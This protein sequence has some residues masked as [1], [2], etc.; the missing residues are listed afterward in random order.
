MKRQRRSA[1][2]WDVAEYGAAIATALD[3]AGRP[4]TLEMVFGPW[5]KLSCE[6]TAYGC[7]KSVRLKG[8]E[9]KMSK[10]VR[11][12]FPELGPNLKRLKISWGR[13][14]IFRGGVPLE[15]NDFPL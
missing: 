11:E 9:L 14:R 13:F 6:M 12:S 15:M 1:V 10:F 5:C 3:K 7:G 8:A 2:A 4:G